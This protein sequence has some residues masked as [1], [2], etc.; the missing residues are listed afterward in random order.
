[1]SAWDFE[2]WRHNLERA[3]VDGAALIGLAAAQ[4]VSG[5]LKDP[6]FSRYEDTGARL[7]HE[8]LDECWAAASSKE[9]CDSGR[10]YTLAEQLAAYANDY[11]Q[12]SL[13]E[14]FHG[15]CDPADATEEADLE[16]FLEEAMPGG[17]VMLHVCAMQALTDLAEVWHRSHWDGALRCLQTAGMMSMRS[18][19]S[20]IAELVDL[21][22][23]IAD[24]EAVQAAQADLQGNITHE[25]RELAVA[26]SGGWLRASERADLFSD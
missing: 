18:D 19:G 11:T 15:L 2:Q 4:R 13:T 23:R 16:E 6:R 7:A 17:A 14:W 3:G 9:A 24:L 12:Q 21:P 10:I 22:Y 8:L 1:V 5:C 20:T 26:A 25:L